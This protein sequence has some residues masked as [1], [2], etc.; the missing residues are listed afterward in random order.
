MLQ[1]INL[2]SAP[3]RR[4]RQLASAW[5]ALIAIAAVFPAAAQSDGDAAVLERRVKA[6]FLY[7][8]LSYVEWPEN[9][10]PKPNTPFTIAVIGDDA[11]AAE[12]AEFA[13]GRATEG[14]SVVVRKVNDP[15]EAASAHILFVARGEN[16]RLSQ[17]VKATQ[18][19]PVLI[20]TESDGALASGSMINFVVSGGRVRFEI[21]V[22]AADRRQLK[23][24]SRLLTVALNVRVGTP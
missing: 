9:A 18:S 12:L 16:P 23:L 22:D 21:S 20:V 6:T 19:K 1:M 7:K 13:G 10:L 2:K 3:L 15:V 14:R 24:S 8:F 4:W 11:L 5:L 17:L